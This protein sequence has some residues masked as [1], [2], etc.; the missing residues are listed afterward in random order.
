MNDKNSVISK[1]SNLV[2]KLN[3]K[4]EKLEGHLINNKENINR[5]NIHQRSIVNT[6]LTNFASIVG[7]FQLMNEYSWNKQ[8]HFNDELLRRL[9]IL[10]IQCDKKSDRP[11]E[12]YEKLLN[13]IDAISE[14][15]TIQSIKRIKEHNNILKDI[16]SKLSSIEKRLDSIEKDNQSNT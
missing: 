4:M 2:C 6:K 9:E 15:F 10:E 13:A 14:Y 1:L 11:L 8:E 3:D 12:S 7:R 16:S 5:Q